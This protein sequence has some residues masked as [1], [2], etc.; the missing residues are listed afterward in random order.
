MTGT[1]VSQT[2]RDVQVTMARIACETIL[3]P[4][5]QSLDPDTGD[6]VAGSGPEPETEDEDD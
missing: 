5:E 1:P 3:R 2:V 6:H 4:D